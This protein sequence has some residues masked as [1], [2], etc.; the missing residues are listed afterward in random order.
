[1]INSRMSVNASFLH[2]HI[3]I[4]R[5]DGGIDEWKEGREEGREV[6]RRENFKIL[7]I[8]TYI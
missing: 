2:I 7:N 3:N 8:Y 5:T 6:E 1:M 4:G